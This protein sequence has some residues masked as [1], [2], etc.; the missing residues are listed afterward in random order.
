[1]RSLNSRD[2]SAKQVDSPSLKKELTDIFRLFFDDEPISFKALNTSR[3][4]EDFREAVTAQTAAGEK[5]MI[6][7][8][9]NDFTFPEKI[10]MWRR[11][12]EEYRR[13]G[14]YCPRILPD[15]AG[16][17]PSVCYNGRSCVAYAEEYSPY[18][19]ADSFRV[20][21][22]NLCGKEVFLNY[23]FR[24]TNVDGY[25]K[26][27]DALFDTLKIVGGYYR[28]SEA[29]K[30]AAILLYRCLKPL[31]SNNPENLK[32]RENDIPAMKSFLDETEN[33]FTADI[34][35]TIYMN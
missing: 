10:E 15:K 26:Q 23:L 33:S 30:R 3:G 19:A 2:E 27:L 28:F 12:V 6:K 4:D 24:E 32:E 22:F 9:D 7:L 13:L 17:Y 25:R 29:E 1:M 21:D 31:W 20:M 35:F 11:T 5:F 16:N 34:D 18:R 14:Y 8:T